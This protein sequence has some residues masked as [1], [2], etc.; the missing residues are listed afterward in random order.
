MDLD[1]IALQ[2][3]IPLL[4]Q[5]GVSRFKS[6]EGVLEIEFHPSQVEEPPQV[7]VVG[8]V[9]PADAL[10]PYERLFGGQMPTFRPEQPQ[11]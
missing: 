2:E 3:L 10:S 5:A 1:L 4:T 7:R 8:P 11:S 6:G 9:R